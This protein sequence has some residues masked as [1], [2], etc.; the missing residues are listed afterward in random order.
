MKNIPIP[1]KISYLIKLIERSKALLKECARKHFFF[2]LNDDKDNPDDQSETF[3]FK[4]RKI[5]P[6]CTEMESFEKD[7][8][9]MIPSIKFKTIK[10]RKIFQL[11]LKEDVNK[12]RKSR[13]RFANKTN[14]LYEMAPKN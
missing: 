9:N 7:L 2:F 8:F 11:K 14:N 6:S 13:N 5:P 1:D 3:G 12:I 4:S 10:K